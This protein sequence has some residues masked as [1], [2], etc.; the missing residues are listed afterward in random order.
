MKKFANDEAHRDSNCAAL[1][2][3]SHGNSTQ[4][5]SSY[6]LG[7]DRGKIFISELLDMLNKSSTLDGKPRLVFIQACRGSRFN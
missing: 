2:V 3:L 1:F 7:S 4:A 5:E 6:V